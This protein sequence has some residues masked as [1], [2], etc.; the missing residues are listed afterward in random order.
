MYLEPKYRVFLYA[1]TLETRKV[2]NVSW[3]C[4]ELF[5][6][7]ALATALPFKV[8]WND[9]LVRFWLVEGDEMHRH[10][11]DIVTRSYQQLWIHILTMLRFSRPLSKWLYASL[12][13]PIICPRAVVF[14]CFWAIF[15]LVI[16]EVPRQS[17]EVWMD[18]YLETGHIQSVKYVDFFPFGKTEEGNRCRMWREEAVLWPYSISACWVRE[19][20][21][22]D[23]HCTQYEKLWCRSN[24]WLCSE[25]D[26]EEKGEGICQ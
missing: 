2:K 13:V 9:L 21:L 5:F 1:S 12:N 3:A 24:C 18:F 26:E 20:H 25:R 22:N 14:N 23:S 17:R 8:C 11:T 7:Q 19:W 6:L 10:N 4:Q 15:P 16:R